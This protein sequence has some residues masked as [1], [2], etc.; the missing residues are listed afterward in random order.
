MLS[1]FHIYDHPVNDL[2]GNIKGFGQDTNAADEVVNQIRA[3]GG[4]AI[5]NYGKPL[6]K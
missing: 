2:G 1:I 4:I 6:V 5:A 3:K